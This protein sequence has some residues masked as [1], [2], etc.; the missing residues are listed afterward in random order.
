EYVERALQ[1]FGCGQVDTGTRERGDR[2]YRAAGSQELQVPFDRTAS[3]VE[4]VVRQSG[5]G[6][7]TCGILEGVE[8]NVQVSELRP[9]HAGAVIRGDVFAVTPLEEVTHQGVEPGSR[10][11]LSP[12]DRRVDLQLEPDQRRHD[13]E[14]A[15]EVEER[16]V[17][18]RQAS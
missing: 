1:W 13:E 10:Q 15:M 7:Y 16:L 9:G 18:H 4:D 11:P 12:F 3:A 8:R 14:V 6:G 2:G 17:E 5:G